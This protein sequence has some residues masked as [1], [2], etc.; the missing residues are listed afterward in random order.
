MRKTKITIESEIYIIICTY[1]IFSS[2][3]KLSNCQLRRRALCTII[4]VN[5]YSLIFI[6]LLTRL[7][8]ILSKHKS[9][10]RNSLAVSRKQM[11]RSRKKREKE[12]EEAVRLLGR[13]VHA[14]TEGIERRRRDGTKERFR[15]VCP[16]RTPAASQMNPLSLLAESLGVRR[17]QPRF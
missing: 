6:Y 2:I 1:M 17:G 11:H 15:R 5:K 10:R 9:V 13:S 3:R 12:K 16:Q 14:W 7:P 4:S 8:S